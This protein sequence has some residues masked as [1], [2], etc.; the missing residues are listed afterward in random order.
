MPLKKLA[1]NQ[2][3]LMD[4]RAG[5][6]ALESGLVDLIITDPPFAINFKAKRANYHRRAERVLEGYHEIT[7]PDYE[8]FTQQWLGTAYRILKD[9]GSMYVFSGW[10]QLKII[11]NTLEDVGFV[12]VNHLIWKYQFGVVTR[13]KF[14]TSHYHC[15]YVCK[16]DKLRRF[17]PFARY[18]KDARDDK[19]HSLH[20]Q[21]KEDVWAI[22]REYWQGD[23]KT[24][25][26]LPAELIRKILAYSSVAGDL[27][28]D[29][30]L[31][32]GQVAVV[33][34]EMNRHYIGFELNREYY[35]FAKTRLNSGQYRLK[36]N[37]S[38]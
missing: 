14:V 13:R 29:P 33:S 6:S 1:I 15:L 8:H 37:R 11:L 28:C 17:Y 25:T 10:N 22:K 4:C 12:V 26:K 19:G 20:Y 21:D 38:N 32:S 27:V 2:I 23:Y 30:F 31:G 18:D 34:K 16:N 3:Y 24:P 35:E 5:M 36:I 9:S 7:Q